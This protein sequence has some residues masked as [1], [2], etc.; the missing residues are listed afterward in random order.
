LFNQEKYQQLLTTK[1]LGHN[2]IYFDE[3]DSTN[4]YM[5]ERPSGKISHGQIC[6]ADYQPRGRG[7]YKR[8][9]QA[10]AGENLTFTLV[11]KPPRP[12]RFHILALACAYALSAQ[13]EEAIQQKALIKWPNDVIINQKKTAGI[14]TETVFSGSSLDRL[15]IG[16]GININQKRF[17]AD[18]QQKATSLRLASGAKISRETF[19]SELLVR[20]ENEYGR[21][22]KRSDDQLKSINQKLAGYGRWVGLQINGKQAAEKC[23]LLGTN[24]QGRLTGIDKEGNLQTFSYEQIRIITD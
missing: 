15:L 21:W 9:W 22:I 23:K 6:L 1:W 5:K 20:L 24:Q 16:I 12:E 14:L 7:Q 18:L 11:F 3:L 17:T 10:Q 8:N 2:L 4:S 13:I 19:L